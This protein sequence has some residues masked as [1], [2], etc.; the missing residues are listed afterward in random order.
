[1]S[2]MRKPSM[3]IDYDEIAD[4]GPMFGAAVEENATPDLMRDLRALR[5]EF[6]EDAADWLLA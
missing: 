2:S 6:M 5:P 1:M 4:W 3:I